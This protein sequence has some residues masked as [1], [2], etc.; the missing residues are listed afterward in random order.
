MSQF[1]KKVKDLCSS[2]NQTSVKPSRGFDLN[3]AMER[4]ECPPPTYHPTTSQNIRDVFLRAQPISFH[5]NGTLVTVDTSQVPPTTSLARFL[6]SHLH[7]TGTKISCNQAGCGACVVSTSLVDPASGEERHMSVNSCITPVYKCQGWKVKTVEGLGSQHAGFHPIQQR[8]AELDGTQ[9]GFCSPGMV[10]MMNG[11]LEGH[12]NPTQKDIEG[13]IDGNICRCTGYRPIFDAFKSFASDAPPELLRKVNDI[14][15]LVSTDGFFPCPKTKQPCQ[16]RCH[17]NDSRIIQF[18]QSKEGNEWIKPNNL[19]DLLALLDDLAPNSSYRLVAGNTGTGIFN[20]DGPYKSFFD[21]SAIPELVT[22]TL[23]PFNVGGGVSLTKFIEILEQ[24]ASSKGV[25]YA[26][27]AQM[28]KHIKKVA[29]T[30][31][32]NVG[33]VGGNLM[34]KHAHKDFPSDIF[35]LLEA[36]QAKIGVKST[37]GEILMYSPVDWL[38]VSMDKKILLF[39]NFPKFTSKHRFMSYK[40]TPRSQNAHAYV[41]G[42]MSIQINDNYD[43]VE[44]PVIVMGGISEL[45]FRPANTENLLVGKNLMARSTLDD[46]LATLESEVVPD[47]NPVLATIQYRTH[48]AKALLYKFILS[49]IKDAVDSSLVSGATQIDRGVSRG[50]VTYDTDPSQYPMQ[51]PIHK[52]EGQIQCTGEAEYVD[53]IPASPGELFAA[54]VLSNVANADVDQVDT[55]LAMTMPGVVEF[56]NFEDI[57]G[58]NSTNGTGTPEEK[59]FTDGKVYYAGQAIGLILAETYEQARQAAKAVIV[60]YINQSKPILDIR[61]AVDNHKKTNVRAKVP[62]VVK[63]RGIQKANDATGP[64]RSVQ[65]EFEIGSQYH[66]HMETQS[67]IVRPIEE[68]QFEVFSAT[69]H[70][71]GVQKSIAMALGINM[72]KI[73]VSVRRLGGAYGGKINQPHFIAAACAVAANKVKRS[74]RLVLDL[75]TN[76]A[77]CGKRV[78][79]LFKYNV[80]VDSENKLQDVTVDVFADVGYNDADEDTDMAKY[81]LQNCYNSPSW[82]VNCFDVLTNTP[83]NTY[84]RAPSSTQGHACSEI[85]ME[86]VAVALGLDPLEFRL[87]NLLSP[88]DPTLQGAPFEGPMALPEIIAALKASCDYDARMA[89]VSTFNQHNSWKKRGLALIPQRWPQDYGGRKYTCQVAI[90]TE[91]GTVAISHGG[92]EMGQGLNTKTVQVVAATLD[93]PLDMISVKVSNNFVANSNWVTGGSRGSELVPAAASMACSELVA[94]MKPIADGLGGSPDWLTLIRE[95]DKQGLDLVAR[96]TTVARNDNIKNYDIWGAACVEVEVDV[97]TGEKNVRRAD[98]VQDTG[99]SISPNID[100]GQVEGAFVMALGLWMTEKI[101]YDPKD[102]RLLTNDTWEYKPPTSQDIPEVFNT[103]FYNNGNASKGVLGAKATGEPPFLLG[104][105]AFIAI[106]NA[107]NAAKEDLQAD[108]T[109]WYELDAPATNEN[110]Q[111]T[112]GVTSAHF[113]V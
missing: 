5:V 63:K 77:L 59:L 10:M 91:D 7:L 25:D 39:I 11:Y 62:L 1:T 97:L 21:I 86:S 23:D 108:P 56:V 43:V 98:L 88:G 105:A 31:V 83:I 40:I 52:L 75:Q 81:W 102:G 13:V 80:S 107:I 4:F 6:R 78:P 67:C 73:N 2:S 103:T 38:S 76:M 109:V 17:P 104:F 19:E 15:D 96:H 48:L 44:R 51:Q 65:G 94:R 26:H 66:F 70:M 22:I 42:A 8:L 72:N 37:T 32:R 58:R 49:V 45:F 47:S 24:Q 71:D 69:Q 29:N 20:D 112:T 50:T 68:G 36:A 28:A 101:K 33:S 30:N 79:Y 61:D 46:A 35:A 3:D 90:Y 34:L 89:E 64:L 113:W 57:P 16:G 27:G 12:P 106:R 100:V 95:C 92:I 53:D 82:K 18:I 111:L 14:E 110:V 60:T 41:N 85:M 84:C 87:G 55:T 74:V 9:C 54:Y 99:A 93:V